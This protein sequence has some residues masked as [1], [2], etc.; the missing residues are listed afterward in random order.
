MQVPIWTFKTIMDKQH[1][2][3]VIHAWKFYTSHL[4]YL[5]AC[6]FQTGSQLVTV[7]KEAGALLN[8]RDNNGETVLDYGTKNWKFVVKY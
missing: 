1:Y 3:M 2:F 6:N 4:I 5:I 8:I 7:L